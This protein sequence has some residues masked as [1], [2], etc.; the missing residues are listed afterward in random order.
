MTIDH[1]RMVSTSKR[2]HRLHVL[3]VATAKST[4]RAPPQIG[5][6]IPQVPA[7]ANHGSSWR[8]GLLSPMAGHPLRMKRT[9]NGMHHYRP[10]DAWN[11]R[12]TR[13]RRPP[14]S[15]LTCLPEG[16]PLGRRETTAANLI[17]TL[18]TSASKIQQRNPYVTEI[19]LSAL[20][21][22][23]ILPSISIGSTFGFA[24]PMC[25]FVIARNSLS[26]M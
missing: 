19:H 3:P 9:R 14:K 15:S 16:S 13:I 5:H 4:N 2:L 20:L 11:V 10:G 17:S 21:L 1:S 18:T 24:S 23:S 25:F 22:C 7:R 8:L 26:C 6:Q 12:R